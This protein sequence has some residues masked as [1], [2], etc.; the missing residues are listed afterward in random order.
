MSPEIKRGAEYSFNTDIWSLGCILY[1]LITLENFSLFF[2]ALITENKLK[3]YFSSFHASDIL[4][5][6]TSL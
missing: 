4:N 2:G 6:M 3:N 1:E 5:K